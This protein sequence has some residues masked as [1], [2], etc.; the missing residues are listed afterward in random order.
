MAYKAIRENSH[1]KDIEIVLHIN[2]GSDGTIEWVKENNIRFNHSEKNLGISTP[3]NSCVDLVNTEFVILLADD[4][5]VLPDWDL[6]LY[7]IIDFYQKNDNLWVAPRLIEPVN[8]YAPNEHIYCAIGNYGQNLETFEEERLLKEWLQFRTSTLKK[9]PCGNVAIKKSIYKEL[10]GYDTS[11]TSGAD[12]DFTYR[13]FKKYGSKGIIQV[14]KSMAYHFGSIVSAANKEKRQQADQQAIKR[15]QELHG[16]F[17][18]D[19]TNLI[20]NSKE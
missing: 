11:Y 14:G 13:F 15:F 18:G 16:F 17:V 1:C 3:M 5:Y 2:E 4:I 12:S 6:W 9:L 8:C 7:N 10:G 19:L 20:T